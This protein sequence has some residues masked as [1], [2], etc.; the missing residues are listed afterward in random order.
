VTLN[1]YV[2]PVHEKSRL[3][4]QQQPGQWPEIDTS[5]LFNF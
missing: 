4:W 3:P 1:A 2:E 5:K